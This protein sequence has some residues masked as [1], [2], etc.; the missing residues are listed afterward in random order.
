MNDILK[1]P[2]EQL[3]AKEIKKLIEADKETPPFNWQMSPKQVLKF[4][5]G[6]KKLGIS[7]KVYGQ[8]EVIERSIV[9]LA[10]NRGLLLIGVPGTA[11]TMISELLSAAIYN[12]SLNTV[13]G[14]TGTSEADLKY[15]WNYAK[16]I[17]EGP[18]LDSLVQSPVLKAMNNGSI[19]RF[20]EITRAPSEVQDMLISIMSDKVMSVPELKENNVFFAKEGFNIIATANTLDQGV[21]EMSSALKRRFNIEVVT[22]LNSLTLERDLV[23]SKLSNISNVVFDDDALTLLSTAFFELRHGKTVDGKPLTIPEKNLS[24]A[25]LEHV[26]LSCST[27]A[28]FFTNGKINL[29]DVAKQFVNCFDKESE[30]DKTAVDFYI[31][32]VIKERAKKQPIYEALYD[33]AKKY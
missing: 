22:P 17:N 2:P 23:K 27:Y 12:D 29:T 19:V 30:K 31:K 5:L 18:S 14:N 6:D 21:N 11:K 28:N 32:S 16:L 1:L 13:Q 26:Y 24:T 25:E 7:K 4:M 9:T 15:T 10:T 20:E 33:V 3:Y 8:D